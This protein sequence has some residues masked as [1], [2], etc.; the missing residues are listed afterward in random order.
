MFVS[1]VLVVRI[2]VHWVDKLRVNC[3]SSCVTFEAAKCKPSL[4]DGCLVLRKPD[5]V[6]LFR[7]A[8]FADFLR[9]EIRLNFGSRMHLD[10]RD[11]HSTCCF[12]TVNFQN[13]AWG[14]SNGVRVPA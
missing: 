6:E 3:L 13:V 7:I 14:F 2:L 8:L 10:C 9:N 11:A 5:V 12:S 4:F 1:L